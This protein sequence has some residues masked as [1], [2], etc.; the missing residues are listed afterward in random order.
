MRARDI[1][2]G[3]LGFAS[4]FL[5]CFFSASERDEAKVGLPAKSTKPIV[6]HLFH[7]VRPYFGIG[8]S[9]TAANDAMM[10]GNAELGREARELPLLRGADVDECRRNADAAVSHAVSADAALMGTAAH[11][12]AEGGVVPKKAACLFVRGH[13]D[14][15]LD[16]F[17]STAS[18]APQG[19]LAGGGG[20]DER[21]C[22][23][24]RVAFV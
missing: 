22:R 14:P 6:S 20:E 17:T 1:D 7:P 11:E 18:R 3:R 13:N 21:E 23:A 24:R 12:L 9:W 2:C 15:V 4:A 16:R 10:F 19:A 5:A 8:Q